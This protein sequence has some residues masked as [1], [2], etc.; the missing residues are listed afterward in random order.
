MVNST[1][2]YMVKSG[3][4][5]GELGFTELVNSTSPE[6]TYEPEQK[7]RVNSGGV[8]IAPPAA[9]LAAPEGLPAC[10]DPSR[11]AAFW[12]V[13]PLRRNVLDTEQALDAAIADGVMLDDVIAGARAYAAYIEAT[14]R[15]WKSGRDYTT[16]PQNFILKRRWLDDWEVKP[17]AATTSTSTSSS[18]AGESKKTGRRRKNPEWIKARAASDECWSATHNASERLIAH[19]GYK[20]KPQGKCQQCYAALWGD[21]DT[22]SCCDVGKPLLDKMR[23]TNKAWRAAE[24]NMP[25]VY[26]DD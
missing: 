20:G 19:A 6:P 24:D 11:Y 21:D 1:S 9:A 5:R 4:Q 17:K 2:L 26:L 23:T 16:Q 8:A 25:P 14:R 22:A 15:N 10:G 13:Y 7:A 12:A 3:A 18:K